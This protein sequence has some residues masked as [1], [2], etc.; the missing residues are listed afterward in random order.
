MVLP[1][2]LL[3]MYGVLLNPAVGAALMIAQSSL[4]LWQVSRFADHGGVQEVQNQLRAMPAI[5]RVCQRSKSI[6]P[7]AAMLQHGLMESPQHEDTS[8]ESCDIEVKAS[9]VRL[10]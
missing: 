3:W 9:A 6:V 2:G 5:H 1:I 4:I 7:A 8:C 10:Y